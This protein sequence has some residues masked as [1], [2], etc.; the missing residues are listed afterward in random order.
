MVA[1]GYNEGPQGYGRG[2]DRVMRAALG[3][4]VSGVVWVTLR[5]KSDP[6]RETNAAIRAAA[7]RWP[8]LLVA[9]WNRHSAGRQWFARDGLHLSTAGAD[10][11]AGFLRPFVLR[12]ARD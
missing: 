6:Y 10:A 1:V 8:Q 2:I 5:E 3:E 12:A 4:G 7:R 9:D 11:L